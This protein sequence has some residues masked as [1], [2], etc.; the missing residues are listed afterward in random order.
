MPR[1][2][3]ARS[4]ADQIATLLEAGFYKTADEVVERLDGLKSGLNEYKK[5]QQAAKPA[6][7]GSA[8]LTR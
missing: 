7:S 3:S 1:N 8:R 4:A 5:R 6:G 2:L